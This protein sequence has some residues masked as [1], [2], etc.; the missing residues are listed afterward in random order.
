MHSPKT[1]PVILSVSE[2]P[3]FFAQLLDSSLALRMTGF[4]IKEASLLIPSPRRGRARVNIPVAAC[5]PSLIPSPR[6]GRARV[7]VKAY[8]TKPWLNKLKL[9]P[10]SQPS[11][12]K[13][14]G[15]FAV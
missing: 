12:L 8:F 13:G 9:L 10:P 2:E 4:K 11:P 6:R 7:R 1:H 5:L 15:V 3:S 14:E